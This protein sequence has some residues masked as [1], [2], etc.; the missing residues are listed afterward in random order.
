MKNV[1][2]L[3]KIFCHERCS[4]M[5]IIDSFGKKTLWRLQNCKDIV[6]ECHRTDVTGETQIKIQSGSAAFFDTASFHWLLIWL[7]RSLESAYVF[8]VFPKVST[9]LWRICRHIIG[10][11]TIRDYIYQVVAWCPPSQLLRNLQLQYF[12]VCLWWE[13]NCHEWFFIE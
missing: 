4:T 11:L 9:T 12:S 1:P 7:W 10:R 5:H 2:V 3:N 8:H 6:C 13:T